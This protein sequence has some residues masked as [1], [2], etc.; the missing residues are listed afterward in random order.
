MCLQRFYGGWEGERVEL[1]GERKE[2]A[3]ERKKLLDWF[4]AGDS[5]FSVEKLMEEAERM[6]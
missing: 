4:A 1:D 3:Q 6:G 2:R 5:R